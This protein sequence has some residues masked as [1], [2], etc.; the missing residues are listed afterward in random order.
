MR[1]MMLAGALMWAAL[2]SAHG[3]DLFARVEGG[4]LV[5]SL[6]FADGTPAAA[7]VVRAFAPDGSVIAESL[8]DE[9][10]AFEMAVD[11]VTR[12]RLVGEAGEG[13]RG[14]YTVSE[15]EIRT[16]V[17]GDAPEAPGLADSGGAETEAAL[18]DVEAAVARQLGPL[19]EQLHAHDRR[20]QLRDILGGIGY[21]FGLAGLL[22]L[23]RHRGGPSRTDGG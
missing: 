18:A 15:A 2:A 5:G 22:V 6:R 20:V 7:K 14:L 21:V 12:Y 23:W 1:F 19:R 16:A 10:G 13:H 3:V 8:T 11:R 4:A 17:S 9:T